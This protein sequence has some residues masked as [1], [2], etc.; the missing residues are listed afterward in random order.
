VKTP[1]LWQP[2]QPARS[3]PPADLPRTLTLRGVPLMGGRLS[4]PVRARVLEEVQ[5]ECLE[6]LS[7]LAWAGQ[8]D[9]TLAQRALEAGLHSLGVTG[10]WHLLP[11]G[12]VDATRLD[13]ALARLDEAS[14][15]LKARLLSACAAC[16]LAD[17]QVTAAEGEIVRAVAASLGCPMPP[18]LAEAGP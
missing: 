18:L 15:P 17:G 8:R 7:A 13:K 9:P 14:A 10:A 16:A 6:L 3:N 5:V 4:T 11:I 1:Y 12:Q 2:I